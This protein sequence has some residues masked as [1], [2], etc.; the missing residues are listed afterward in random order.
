MQQKA[1]EAV[2]LIAQNATRF[3]KKCVVLCLTGRFSRFSLLLHMGPCCL[4]EPSSVLFKTLFV[5]ESDAGGFYC[6]LSPDLDT[7]LNI[8]SCCSLCTGVVEKV[9]DIKT[10]I[11]ATKCLTTFCEAVGPKLVFERV[12]F[13]V[14]CCIFLHLYL[15]HLHPKRMYHLFDRFEREPFVMQLFKIMKDHK[16]PKVLGEGLS[17]MATALDDFGIGHVPLKVDLSSVFL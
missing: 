10:R 17:W 11:Q 1:I 13:T 3:S 2:I 12:S 6:I 15:W 16:N 8:G 5:P 4:E 7:L 9:G 14:C